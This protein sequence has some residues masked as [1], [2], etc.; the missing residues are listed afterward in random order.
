MNGRNYLLA[1]CLTL[2]VTSLGWAASILPAGL[3]CEYLENPLGMDVFR[4]RLSWRSESVDPEQRGQCQTA[5]RILVASTP[6]ALAADDGDLWDS[7]EVRSGACVNV[8]YAGRE[9]RAGQACHWKVR[10]ADGEGVWSA[11]SRPARWTVGLQPGDWTA[12]WIGNREGRYLTMSRDVDAEKSYNEMRDPW[13]RREFF[14]ETPPE[15]GVMYVASVG[16]HELY[17]N[18]RRV[19]D[20]VLAP[21]TTDHSKRARYVTYDITEYLQ[22][23]ANAVALWLGMSWAMFP[24]Y[25]T[26]DKPAAP[27]VIAQADIRLADGKTFRVGTDRNW[28]TR[29]SPNRMIGY[30]DAHHFGGEEYDARLEIDGWNEAGFDDAA[31]DDAV[32]YAPALLLSSDKTEPNRRVK[33]MLPRRIERLENGDYRVDMGVSFTGWFALAVEGRAGDEV[34]FRF[35][36]KPDERMSFGQHSIYR[37][38][39][40][41]KGRFCNRFNY[42]TGRWVTVS[43]LRRAPE[44]K[45]IEAWMIR[46]DFRRAGG[47][48]C[49]DSLLNRV[50]ETAMWTAE[51]LML[52]SYVVDC[53][54]RERRGYGGDAHATTRMAMDNY[55]LEA[56]YTKWMEDWRDTQASDGDVPYTAPTYEGGGGPAWSGYCVTLPWEMHRRYGDR[57]V[58]EQ[59]YPVICRW[60]SFLETHAQ[61]DMLVRWGGV[62]SFLGDWI[63]PGF[64]DERRE[65]ARN[66]LAP[67]DT[68]EALF[69]NNCF[70]IYNLMQ[71]ADIAAVLGD[72][73]QAEAWR[74]RAQQVR[75]AV[76]R[77]FFNPEDNSYVNG[78]QSYLAVALEVGLPPE[79]LREKVWKR[80]EEEILVRRKGHFWGGI[81]AGAMLFHTLLDAGRDDLLY[82]MIRQRDFPG[83][84]YMLDTPSGTFPEDWTRGGTNLHSSYLYV[85]SWFLESLGGIKIPEAGYGRFVLAP[86]IDRTEGPRRVASHYDSPYGRIESRWRV[87][88]TK[89]TLEVAVPANTAAEL[90]LP[91]L[92]GATLLESGRPLAEAAGVERLSDGSGRIVLALEPG[93]YLFSGDF[94]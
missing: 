88:G 20:Q 64:W 85:G 76:H 56:F 59:S 77:M 33:R 86:W 40:S 62:W 55:R 42:M 50:Y 58:L 29:L 28:K 17:V 7:G 81:T 13:L 84:I 60:L 12:L 53:P 63:W 38:G 90:H 80:L 3:R 27:I 43:G 24:A 30:W 8:A 1:A 52:G 91:E 67:G 25:Q 19:G 37:I 22:P 83:W 34:T 72:G 14:L 16:Y 87:A 35:S 47:F 36:E 92:D 6:E 65:M 44:P 61:E 39:P 79:E 57:R 74:S 75:Q 89:V 68:R 32:T 4:P 94:R 9:L 54:H 93:R 18:G 10:V 15:Y 26:D 70:W 5:Y 82:T 49:D 31:W 46:T 73:E 71:A 21:S 66:G 48:E 41:G 69:F 11:W 51:N 78:F 45:D 2:A 23:G